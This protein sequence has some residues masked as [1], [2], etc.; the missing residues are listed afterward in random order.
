MCQKKQTTSNLLHSLW[1]CC[2]LFMISPLIFLLF[3]VC[4][5]SLFQ[6]SLLSL[7]GIYLL[8]LPLLCTLPFSLSSNLFFV[9]LAIEFNYI[10][11]EE[12]LPLE[13][14]SYALFIKVFLCFLKFVLYSDGYGKY[15]EN[16]N[17]LGPCIVIHLRADVLAVILFEAFLSP[18]T[19]ALLYV[20]TS[21]TTYIN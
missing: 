19:L 14:Y 6:Y 5:F 3:V 1:C 7:W 4:T 20:N 12:D 10:A 18:K 13:R 8:S 16:Y 15:V 9:L 11:I 17:H 2:V 21:P